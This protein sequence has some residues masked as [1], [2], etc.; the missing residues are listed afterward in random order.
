MRLARERSMNESSYFFACR[1]NIFSCSSVGA[2][3]FRRSGFDSRGA[4][5]GVSRTRFTRTLRG[6]TLYVKCRIYL[7]NLQGRGERDKRQK[8]SGESQSS[9]LP[10]CRVQSV[11]TYEI[12]CLLTLYFMFDIYAGAAYAVPNLKQGKRTYAATKREW[13]LCPTVGTRRV[14][15]TCGF[16]RRLC[17]LHT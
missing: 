17:S 4:E 14:S 6:Q 11:A 5:K 1:P 3:D 7:H 8:R 10:L 13:H 16:P 12:Y 2:V 9:S 15:G